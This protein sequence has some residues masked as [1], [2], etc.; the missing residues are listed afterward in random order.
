MLARQAGVDRR[1]L[2]PVV[3]SDGAAAFRPL[4]EAL[5]EAAADFY[6][7]DARRVLQAHSERRAPP[8]EANARTAFKVD[9]QL[10]A[11]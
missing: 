6:A 2:V 3:L 10:T 9:G 1:C 11:N 8:P 5:Y 7:D 4:G